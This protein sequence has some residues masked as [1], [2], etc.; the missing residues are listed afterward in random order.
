MPLVETLA[1]A[2]T[3]FKGEDMN[4]KAKTNESTAKDFSDDESRWQAVTARVLRLGTLID[5]S[6]RLP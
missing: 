5:V 1:I 3:V 4:G 6:V 2:Q